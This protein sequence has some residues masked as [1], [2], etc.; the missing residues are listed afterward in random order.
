M[1]PWNI[2]AASPT[3]HRSP[4]RPGSRRSDRDDQAP[5]AAA[6]AA[7]RRALELDPDQIQTYRELAYLYALQRRK[8][9][10]GDIF[11][12]LDERMKMG[13]VLA[14]AWARTT[15][16]SGPERGA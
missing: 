6:I 15:A 4:P 10:C 1:T 16:R 13:Y 5:R 9:D 11:L 3:R 2:W 14:F 7:F 8:A 12:A